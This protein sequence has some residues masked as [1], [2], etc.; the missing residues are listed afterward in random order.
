[1]LQ[2][3]SSYGPR[4]ARVIGV[5]LLLVATLSSTPSAQSPAAQNRGG[6]APQ[7]KVVKGRLLAI[8]D[9]HGALEPPVGSAGGVITSDG[10][11]VP[12]GG[13]A[14]LAT[15]L[16]RLRAAAEANGEQV[17]TAAAGDLVGVSPLLN[18]AFH[19]EPAIDAMSALGLDFSAIGHGE[20][21]EGLAELK[22]LQ[23]GG[24]HPVDG[25]QDGD[26]FAGAGF[27]YLAANLVDARTKLPVF[28]PADIRIV[29]GVPIGIVGITARTTPQLVP[30]S[31]LQGVQLL[32]EVQTANFYAGLMRLVGIRSLVLLIHEGGTQQAAPADPSGCA[33]FSGAIANI[34]AGL[35]P[36][37]G[38]VISG[39]THQAYACVLPNAAGTPSLVTSAGSHGR[40][41]TSIG[42][43][44]DSRT[45]QFTSFSTENV[46]VTRD[47]ALDPEMVQL[48]QKYKTALAPVQNRQVGTIAADITRQGAPSGESAL[49]NLVADAQLA[50]TASTG[51]QIALVQPGGLRSDL[52]YPASGNEGNGAVTYVEAYTVQP[53]DELLVTVTLT[54]AQLKEAL[55]QQ[56]VGYAGQ[57]FTKI[58][59]IS[60]GLSY[61]YSLS[62][63][64]GNKVSGMKLNGVPIDSAASYRVAMSNFLANGG[65]GFSKL[66]VGTNRTNGP[67]VDLDALIE[68]LGAHPNIAPPPTGRIAVVP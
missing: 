67:G 1:M 60:S 28:L 66:T 61:T 15:H 18:K 40:L 30:S 26:G 38:I 65:D 58:L 42:F 43:T 33:S 20:L 39:H 10:T 16:A 29:G 25:C 54:G 2:V 17:L 36:E 11:F 44:I 27:R 7:N 59:S 21:E 47:V 45:K 32:D 8:N 13:V 53:F 55:E 51:S 37:Y 6:S 9:F 35:R 23:R 19:E 64:S 62:A 4:S 31:A 3:I 41:V 46:V 22:R 14:Y 48:V 24:C 5:V 68:Y 57:P 12:A 63:A 50:Y 52:R 49:G 34:V 56:F